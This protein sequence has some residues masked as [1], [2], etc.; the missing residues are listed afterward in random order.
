MVGMGQWTSKVHV[1]RYT[2]I[3][4]ESEMFTY[5]GTDNYSQPKMQ[6]KKG[7]SHSPR[8]LEITL[9]FLLGKFEARIEKRFEAR[10]A[11]DRKMEELARSITEIS[12]FRSSSPITEI[13]MSRESGMY[14]AKP[15]YT[16]QKPQ[17]SNTLWPDFNKMN[18]VVTHS[19]VHGGF[20]S[21]SGV[22]RSGTGSCTGGIPKF[23][24]TAPRTTTFAQAGYRLTTSNA[25][26]SAVASLS[27][28]DAEE[29]MKK[30]SGTDSYTIDSWINQIE[31]NA[32][33]M[34]WPEKHTF[35]YAKRLLTGDAADLIAVSRNVTSWEALQLVLRDN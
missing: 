10:D 30:F 21:S 19:T 3:P 27:T 24:S 5:P 31:E 32:Q 12:K 33:L 1:S 13:T 15:T 29:S 25:N 4:H 17:L 22:A 35:I 28:R 26:Y 14:Q 18:T 9:I 7:E 16:Q 20:S 34:N 11:K 2:D 23:S 8:E 6:A